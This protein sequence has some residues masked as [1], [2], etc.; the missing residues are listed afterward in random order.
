MPDAM[1]L[2]AA[3]ASASST[4]SSIGHLAVAVGHEGHAARL[5]SELRQDGGE[6][7]QTAPGRGPRAGVDV[8]RGHHHP[9][10]AGGEV[11][12]VA[13]V[14]VH[15]PTRWPSRDNAPSPWR[16][17]PGRRGRAVGADHD[18]APRLSPAVPALHERV[19]GVADAGAALPVEH[20]PAAAS[21]ASSGRRCSRARVIRVRRV[22]K[23]NTST[24]DVATRRVGELHEAARYRPS[25]PR[26]PG[27]R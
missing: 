15:P 25:I 27:S 16:A 18:D 13:L 11:G 2:H 1:P 20:P 12:A 22:P 21:S 5:P 3:T 17:P 19:E 6:R 9:K 4:I 24:R 26:R 23:Q 14:G 7:L 8:R 10:R